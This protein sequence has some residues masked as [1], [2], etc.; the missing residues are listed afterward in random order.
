MCMEAIKLKDLQR[1]KMLTVISMFK[2]FKK[3]RFYISFFSN[4]F[5]DICI[6]FCYKENSHILIYKCIR[7]S[8]NV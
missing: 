1:D 5:L 7:N 8:N 2:Y 3:C 4:C 6:N